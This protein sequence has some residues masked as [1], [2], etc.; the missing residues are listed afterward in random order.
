MTRNKGFTLVE[1]LMVVIILGIL[2]AIVIP[3]FTEA[4][5]DARDSSFS[6]DLQ[7][8]RSQVELYK[9]QHGDL[10]PDNGETG[11]AVSDNF[12]TRMIGKTDKAGAMDTGT[13]GPYLQKFPTNPFPASNGDKVWVGNAAP[14]KDVAGWW[15]DRTKSQMKGIDRGG[16][17]I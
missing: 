2:A 5:N 6:S 12:V 14:G 16:L 17:W 10:S 9:V 15:W 3:Q 8:L 11:D 7:T 4:S 13:L 1:I